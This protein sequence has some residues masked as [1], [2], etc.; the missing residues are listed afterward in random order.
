MVK[1][2][3]YYQSKKGDLYKVLNPVMDLNGNKLTQKVLF[4]AV[5]TGALFTMTEDDFVKRFEEAERG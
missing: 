3:G 4:M 5:G 1:F 2:G